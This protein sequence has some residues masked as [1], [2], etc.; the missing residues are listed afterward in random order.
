MANTHNCGANEN[1]NNNNANPPPPPTL[2]QVLIM[3]A[4]MLQTMQQTVANM[5]QAQGQQ[6]TPQPQQRDK[7]GEFQW[8]KPPTFSHS[9][10]PM[11]ADDWLKT[12]EKKL[13][14]VQCNNREKVLFASH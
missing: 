10:E 9:V 12:I 13:Q 1:N 4:Q 11:D 5:Q 7:L 8:A 6:P 2:E 3:Q 14:V